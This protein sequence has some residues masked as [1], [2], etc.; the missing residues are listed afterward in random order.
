M[1]GIIIFTAIWGLR[2][3]AHQVDKDEILAQDFWRRAYVEQFVI[4]Y[5][6]AEEDKELQR[7]VFTEYAW[8]WSQH[9]P[10]EILLAIK[11]KQTDSAKLHPMEVLTDKLGKV[12]S[13]PPGG[14]GG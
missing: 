9:S 5:P 2:W 10:A 7:A 11:N 4:K 6:L 12:A 3:Y 14:S 8:N 13:K 1:I